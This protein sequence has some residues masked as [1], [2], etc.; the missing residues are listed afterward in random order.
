MIVERG[1]ALGNRLKPV[2]EIYHDL[3]QWQNEM[4]FHTV[5]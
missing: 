3:T 2:I 1:I 4:Q 5:A